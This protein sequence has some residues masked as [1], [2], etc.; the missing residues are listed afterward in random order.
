MKPAP[1]VLRVID[2]VILMAVV[3]VAWQATTGLVRTGLTAGI[4]LTNVAA[5]FRGSLNAYRRDGGS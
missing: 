4:L 5:Y 3:F 1:L 2:T